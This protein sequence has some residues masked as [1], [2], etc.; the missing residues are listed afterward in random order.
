M[1]AT[2]YDAW[3]I[4]EHDLPDD[5]PLGLTPAA[6]GYVLVHDLKNDHWS[7]LDPKA[8]AHQYEFV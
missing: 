1:A 3:V 6:E 8:F 4:G 7:M 2:A 5:R